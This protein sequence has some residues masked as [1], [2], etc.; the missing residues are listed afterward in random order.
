MSILAKNISK[1]YMTKWA[2]RGVSVDI[3]TGTVAG[4]LGE[5]GSGKSTLLRILAGITRPTGGDVKLNDQPLTTGM[6]RSISY[7][8]E[9]DSLY[10]WMRVK[11]QQEFLSSFYPDWDH[12]KSRDLISLMR[13]GNDEKISTL[14][15]GQRGRLGVALAFSR[16]ASVV[17]LD[18]PF[19]GIDPPSRKRILETLIS[20][21]REEDQTILMSTHLVSEVEGTIEHV[22]YIHRGEIAISGQSDAL[23]ETRGKSLNEIFD[24]VIFGESGGQL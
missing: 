13:L 22:H 15:K 11:Q 12:N 2:L 1:R 10:G 6:K 21:F 9:T 24:T 3:P 5:N 14:S 23:R 16:S 7:V 8:T 18:E 20:E 4:L 19:G 17:L